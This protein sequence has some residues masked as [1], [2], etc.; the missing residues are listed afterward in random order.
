MRSIYSFL[1][2]FLVLFLV[3]LVSANDQGDLS[4]PDRLAP[5]ISILVPPI[6]LN[7]YLAYV[8]GRDVLTI[9]NYGASGA[10]RDVIELLLLHQALALGGRHMKPVLQSVDSYKRILQMLGTGSA[11]LSGTT[12]WREDLNLHRDSY[13]ITEP[14]I[15][16]GMFEVGVYVPP[17]SPLLGLQELPLNQLSAVSSRNW[18][19]DWRTLNNMGLKKVE[20]GEKWYSMVKMV[21]AGRAD[22]LLAP[23]Q[24]SDDMSLNVKGLTLLPVPG[25]K[26]RLEGSRHFVVSKDHPLGAQVFAELEVG[27][28]KLIA[29]GDI[30]RAYKES[31][32]FHQAVEGWTLLN[33]PANQVLTGSL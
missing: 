33:T 14:V 16:R 17:E 13:W 19:V 11:L 23:F 2:I 31:G 9:T 6:V 26:V 15:S 28:K 7:D 4:D 32:T 27:R 5:E 8:Q 18:P 29:R 20:D 24:P 10:R 25:V 3:P 22:F 30:Q 21:M 1:T 12:V